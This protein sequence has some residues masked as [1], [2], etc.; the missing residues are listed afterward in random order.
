M[1]IIAKDGN[2][3]YGKLKLMSCVVETPCFMP[4]ATKGAVKHACSDDLERINVQA[5]IANAMILALTVGDKKIK[6]FGGIHKYM[7]FKKGIFT[8]S[9]GFQMIRESFHVKTLE[10]GVYFKD[11]FNDERI[12]AT[13]EWVVEI[14]ENIGSDVAMVLDDHNDYGLS[15]ETH[16]KAV[17]RTY[18]WAKRCLNAKKDKKQQ[19]WGIIQGGT[20][21]DLR[22][23]STKLICSLDFD[24]YA[25]G[26]LGIGE[27]FDEFKRAVE[28]CI[29]KMP[30][31]KPRYVMGVG[32][33]LQMLNA[34]ELGIDFFDS[35]YPTQNA[36]HSTLFT[37]NGKIDLNK[38]KFK[39]D[40]NPVDD[41]CDCYVCKNFSKAYLYH[42]IKMEEPIAMRYKTIHNLRFMHQLLEEAREAIKK[43]KFV[44]FKADFESKFVSKSGEGL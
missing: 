5:V 37:R 8:D 15:K 10:S 23:E 28:V 35:T 40:N 13:P 43:G 16:A 18:D 27:S 6:E 33:P 3:R 42:L 44:E 7:G 32:E 20:F 36:R 9:G 14:Q 26:G 25:I 22:E 39:E 38:A 41:S 24:G 1:E 31:E 2:A 34:I 17:Q 4:V 29:D 19:L 30:E 11:M 21:D 12:L